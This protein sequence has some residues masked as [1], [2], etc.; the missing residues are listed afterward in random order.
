MCLDKV[1]VLKCKSAA[2]SLCFQPC[3]PI[4]SFCRDKVLQLQ[5][6]NAGSKYRRRW[7]D[8]MPVHASYWSGSMHRIDQGPCIVSETLHYRDCQLDA[9]LNGVAARAGYNQTGKRNFRS[10]RERVSY[11]YTVIPASIILFF[12][13]H[14]VCVCVSDSVRACVCVCQCVCVWLACLAHASNV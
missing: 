2:A 13:R 12:G 9:S 7:W 14:G 3:R 5:V 1:V 8:W 10:V 4:R 6:W 11:I